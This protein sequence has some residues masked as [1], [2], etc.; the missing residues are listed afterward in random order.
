MGFVDDLKTVRRT[1]RRVPC[2]LDAAW[3]PQRQ[4][5]SVVCGRFAGCARQPAVTPAPRRATSAERGG[6]AGAGDPTVARAL[7]CAAPGL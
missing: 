2:V 1:A 6:A 5:N 4:R 3:P 7:A